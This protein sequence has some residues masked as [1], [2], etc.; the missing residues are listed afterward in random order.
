MDR[1]ICAQVNDSAPIINKEVFDAF[2]SR[3]ELRSKLREAF[4]KML[5][6]YGF[7]LHA[8][9]TGILTVCISLIPSPPLS[10]Y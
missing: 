5:W 1:L 7:E 4:K 6:F 2:R 3:P 10:A 9:D 8:S